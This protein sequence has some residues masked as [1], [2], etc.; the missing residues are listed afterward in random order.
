MPFK[1]SDGATYELTELVPKRG[2]LLYLESIVRDFFT[3]VYLPHL[4]PKIWTPNYNRA[5][6]FKLRDIDK[7]FSYDFASTYKHKPDCT[8]CCQ[9]FRTT[10]IEVVI[11]DSAPKNTI[12]IRQR[13]VIDPKAKCLKRKKLLDIN[14]K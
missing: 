7:R 10:N 8:L 5:Q 13:S 14:E 1:R 3:E 6:R 2:P 9:R 4:F 12:T 11:V